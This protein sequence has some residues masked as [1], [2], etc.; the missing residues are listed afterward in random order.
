MARF[1][2]DSKANVEAGNAR[3]FTP[4]LFACQQGSLPFASYLLKEAK[5]NVA[6]RT[7]TGATAFH[8]ACRFGHLPV[9]DYLLQA[10]ADVQA[11]QND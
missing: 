7:R 6:T 10:G 8:V 3:G 11:S 5:A 9:I 2:V 4:L 1:L